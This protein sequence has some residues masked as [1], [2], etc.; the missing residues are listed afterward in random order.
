MYGDEARER[1]AVEPDK[2]AG[3]KTGTRGEFARDRADFVKRL[4]LTPR[5][6]DGPR[7]P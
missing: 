3:A 7:V 2:R 5:A 6:E 1:R 4:N